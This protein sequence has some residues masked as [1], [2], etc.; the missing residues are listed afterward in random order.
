M[1]L[2]VHLG[3]RSD[4]TFGCGQGVAGL[5]DAE[6]EHDEWGLPFLRGRAL[7]G[8][9]AW[10]CR[11]ILFALGR[12][13]SPASRSMEAAAAFL[14]G[15]PGSRPDDAG[16]L[17]VGPARLPEALREA[18]QADVAAQR[19]SRTD[20]LDA[21]T[22]VRF[23]TSVDADGAPEEGSLR[24]A[25]VLLRGT[26]LVAPLDFEREPGGDDLALLAAC[27]RSVRRGGT[28]R[29]RGRGRLTASLRSAGGAD[30]TEEYL[31]RFRALVGGGAA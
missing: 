8:L 3:L 1:R 10:E 13:R 28:G 14:F 16:A 9:L 5:V 17:R 30:L 19:L 18:V 4:A 25:R 12:Q 24:V 11:L 21:L 7:K 26:V 29:N 22:A 27:V 6:I 20:V 15:T 31:S 23:Q 2:E